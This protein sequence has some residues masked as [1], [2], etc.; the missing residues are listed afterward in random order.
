VTTRLR[1]TLQR[2]VIVGSLAAVGAC[3]ASQPPA[4]SGS[5]VPPASA[6]AAGSDVSGAVL[7]NSWEPEASAAAQA[8]R[9]CAKIGANAV[10]GSVFPQ[11]TTTRLLRYRCVTP[12]MI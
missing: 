8:A 3:G 4:L 10:T 1:R 7:F 9:A 12:G 2:I 11:G 5:S 6:A